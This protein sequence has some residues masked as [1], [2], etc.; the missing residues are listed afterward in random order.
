MDRRGFLKGTGLASMAG[1]AAVALSQ[2]DGPAFRWSRS[3]DL[4]VGD[5]VYR[6]DGS[7][8]VY[9]SMDG[10]ATWAVHSKLAERLSVRAIGR[11]AGRRVSIGVA[12][13]GRQFLLYLA[14][15]QLGWQTT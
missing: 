6:V 8:R 4:A 9:V 2:A 14:D 15:D 3:R 10:G 1:V 7:S 12:F 5:R 13:S 11:G